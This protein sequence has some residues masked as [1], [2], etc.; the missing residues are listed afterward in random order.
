MNSL[1]DVERRTDEPRTDKGDYQGPPREN[2]ASKMNTLQLKDA[3]ILRNPET[4]RH[5][6][7]WKNLDFQLFLTLGMIYGCFR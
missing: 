4:S 5:D 7:M 1:W 3:K 6:P 2:P